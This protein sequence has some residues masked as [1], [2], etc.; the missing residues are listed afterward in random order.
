MSAPSPPRQGFR[1][2]DP[3]ENHLRRR[4]G[5]IATLVV[6]IT[7][8]AATLRVAVGSTGFFVLGFL[9]A[10][11]WIVGSLLSG[12]VPVNPIKSSRLAVTSAA[13]V[14][15]I[16]AFLGFL[17]ADLV[18]RHLP[19]ISGA[20]HTVLAKADTGP[21]GLVLV[22]ALLNGLGEEL[23]FRGAL[24]AALGSHRPVI[25]ST[26]LYVAVTA[27]TGNVALVI[28]A[29]AMGIIFSLQRA[30]TGGILAPTITHLCWSTLMIA[31][32]PR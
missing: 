17:A 26:V 21:I 11:T 12:P 20:L 16:V 3:K 22:V 9:T 19:L 13:L 1:R 28:A 18:G 15:S 23:F 29:L 8:L 25:T 30:H 10:S 6:G 32:L 5:V 7:L 2:P 24:F 31:A 4:I 27:A 14:L